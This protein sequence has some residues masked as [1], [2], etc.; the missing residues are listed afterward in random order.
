MRNAL[1]SLTLVSSLA[2]AGCLEVPSSLNPVFPA[3]SAVAVP[4]IEGFW[5]DAEGDTS[6]S[7]RAAGD[8]AYEMVLWEKDRPS[9]E[10]ESFE[11]HFA[12]LGDELFWDLIP[13]GP[14]A[15]SGLGVRRVHLPARVRL[16]DGVL[17]IAF[18]KQDA[19]RQALESGELTLA[20]ALADD[21]LVLTGSTDELAAF[22]E[23]HARSEVLFDE[24]SSFRKRRAPRG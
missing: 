18:L 16:E 22:L 19:V 12:R 1:S 10:H 20:H 15:G 9:A 24:P 13:S 2:L 3:A 21:D 14:K 23:A 4:G 11:L 5:R 8:G 7:I 17:E 6:L